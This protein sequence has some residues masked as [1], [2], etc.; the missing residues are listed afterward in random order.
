MWRLWPSYFH[1]EPQG[2]MWQKSIYSLVVQK[3]RSAHCFYPLQKCSFLRQCLFQ[4]SETLFLCSQAIFPNKTVRHHYFLFPTYP[5]IT[6]MSIFRYIGKFVSSS[7]AQKVLIEARVCEVSTDWGL[8]PASITSS[9]LMQE[10]LLQLL[11]LG[12]WSFILSTNSNSQLISREI[13]LW[14][15]W[16]F[17]SMTSA[18]A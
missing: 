16:T 18:S 2:N 9:D 11:L 17:S 5:W 10:C 7:V 13:L 12:D 6:V 8:L 3:S 4:G 15:V 14:L 1:R